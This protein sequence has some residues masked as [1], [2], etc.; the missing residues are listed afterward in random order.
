[1]VLNQ[2]EEFLKNKKVK[3]IRIGGKTLQE[4]IFEYV[5]NFQEDNNINVTVLSLNVSDQLE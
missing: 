1:M 3:Y 2:I 5:K 4:I